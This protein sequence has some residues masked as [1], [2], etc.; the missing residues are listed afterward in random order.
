[1]QDIFRDQIWQ[2]IGAILG[3]VALV[4]TIIIYL[5]QRR[6]KSLVY[7]VVTSA[8]LLSM[9]DEVKGKVQ[10]LYEGSPVQL[11]H[12]LIINIFNDGNLGIQA[13]DFE[14]PL[15]FQFGE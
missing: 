13:S 12:L 9:S 15:V 7:E 5:L 11:V 3:L 2:F 1:M 6:K 4:A 14:R 10:I 8:P